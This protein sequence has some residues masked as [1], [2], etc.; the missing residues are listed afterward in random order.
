MN[1]LVSFL[2]KTF[3]TLWKTCLKRGV[4]YREIPQIAC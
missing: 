4:G 1:Q 3:Q 2:Q